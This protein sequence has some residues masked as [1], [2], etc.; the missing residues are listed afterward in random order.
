[1]AADRGRLHSARIDPSSVG[2]SPV[3]TPRTA[4]PAWIAVRNDDFVADGTSVPAG[5]HFVMR[6]TPSL[7]VSAAITGVLL[8][9]GCATV[10]SSLMV[11]DKVRIDRALGGVV[12]IDA[13]GTSKRAFVGRPLVTDDALQAAVRTAVLESGVF[14]EVAEY[15]N[16]DRILSVTIERLEEPEVGLDQT[17]M[18]AVRWKLLTGDRSRTIWEELITTEETINSFDELDSESRSG[19]AIEAALRANVQRGLERMSHAG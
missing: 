6:F 3:R 12:R 2:T 9:H 15:G 4:N 17:S 5:P 11:P 13:R 7:L 14:D 10:S 16:S 8:A 18:V 19:M 1:M